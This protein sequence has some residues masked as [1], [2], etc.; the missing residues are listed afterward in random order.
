MKQ[1]LILLLSFLLILGTL[2]TVQAVDIDNNTFI[3]AGDNTLYLLSV[4]TT[5]SISIYNVTEDNYDNYFDNEGYLL[6]NIKENDT[7]N[8]SGSFTGKSFI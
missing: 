3:V 4:N 2:S 8:L 5:N 6:N 7:L 1:K